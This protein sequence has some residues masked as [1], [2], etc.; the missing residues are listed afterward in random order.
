MPPKYT[1]QKGT[2]EKKHGKTQCSR[3][4]AFSRFNVTEYLLR[5]FC[6]W[7][8]FVTCSELSFW[9]EELT[10]SQPLWGANCSIFTWILEDFQWL[11]FFWICDDLWLDMVPDFLGNVPDTSS[12]IQKAWMCWYIMPMLVFVLGKNSRNCRN[13][14]NSRNCLDLLK[15]ARPS[16]SLSVCPDRASG[17][18]EKTATIL[19]S[20][21]GH[22]PCWM[23]LLPFLLA[24]SFEPIDLYLYILYFFVLRHWGYRP[25]I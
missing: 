17:C 3:R 21:C 20:F 5:T 18:K 10:G 9:D 15:Y 8:I 23:C 13:C 6:I 16:Q 19:W 11:I 24:K 25:V 4:L 22:V 12:K 1:N 7:A 2:T 14:L